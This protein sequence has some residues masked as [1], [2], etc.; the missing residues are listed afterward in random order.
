[1]LGAGAGL[2]GR[3]TKVRAATDVSVPEWLAQATSIPPAMAPTTVATTMARA[4]RMKL[5]VGAK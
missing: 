1:M 5:R 3:S 2:T 4:V